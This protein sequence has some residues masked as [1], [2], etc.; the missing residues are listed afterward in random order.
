[1][2]APE[3]ELDI[4][5]AYV[6]YEGRR[7]GLGEEFLSSVDACLESIRRRLMAHA[8]L[9]NAISMY[10]DRTRESRVEIPDRGG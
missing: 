6:W 9:W 10:T 2:I 8:G 4:A 7:A 5:E 1:V 3:A